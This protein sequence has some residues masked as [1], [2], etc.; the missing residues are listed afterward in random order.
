MTV[1]ISNKSNSNSNNNRPKNASSAIQPFWSLTRRSLQFG[2]LA[3][4]DVNFV[5]VVV[6]VALVAADVIDVGAL[7]VVGSLQ[8][9]AL[10]VAWSS[11]VWIS[12]V[13]SFGCFCC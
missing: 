5:A 6:V 8:F 7:V 13:W 9:G 10:V 12:T 4:A 2:A 1:M 11:T 3:I